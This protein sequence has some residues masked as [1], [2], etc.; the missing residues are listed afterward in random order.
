VSF[1]LTGPAAALLGAQTTLVVG[2]ITAALV[3]IS[4]LFV[5]GVRDTEH[6]GSMQDARLVQE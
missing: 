5:P 2:G 1:A 6:D 3:T 4:F